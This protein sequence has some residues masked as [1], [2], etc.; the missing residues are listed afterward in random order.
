[1]T[2]VADDD[3]DDTGLNHQTR[4]RTR[5][6]AT[7]DAN[8]NTGT[9]TRGGSTD[10]SRARAVRDLTDDG[11]GRNNVDHSRHHTNDGTRHNTR[12]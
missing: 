5:G 3:D 10:H 8:T 7:N 6:G 4:T 12:G 11:P 9:R 2:T 1:M